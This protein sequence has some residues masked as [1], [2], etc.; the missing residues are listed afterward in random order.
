MATRR[1]A[2]NPAKLRA[3]REAMESQAPE[4]APG[5]R[6]LLHG[7]LSVLLLHALSAALL[8][9]SFA[10]FNYWY[11]AYVALVP[12]SLA[13]LDEGRPRWGLL[14]S[15]LGGVLFWASNLYWLWWITL[16]GYF[17]LV[18]YLSVYWLVGAWVVR[19]A[20]RRRIPAWIA[21]PLIWTSLEYARAHV[22]SGFPWLFLAHSQYLQ[23]RLIQIVD[24]TGQYGVS[25]FVALV[26]GVLVELLSGPLVGR[27]RC[28][29]SL[30]RGLVGASVAA[31]AVAGLM[32]YGHW[33]VN[34]EVTR[35]GPVIGVVQQD[36]R[37]ALGG[38]DATPEKT[39][40]SHLD[41]TRE[42]LIGA[43]CDLVVWPETMLPESLNPEMLELDLMGLSRD[44]LLCL[45]AIVGLS[46]EDA[47]TWPD[48]GLR[49]LLGTYLHSG[50]ALPLEDRRVLQVVSSRQHAERVTAL[51]GKLDCPI[52]AGGTTVH[53]SDDPVDTWD[54]FV[55]RN[56]LLWFDG[57]GLPEWK[58]AKRHLVPLSEFV[59]F[60][61]TWPW[62]YAQLRRLIPPGM[63]QL[64]PGDSLEPLELTNEQGDSWRLAAAICYEGTFPRVCR[65][66][67]APEGRKEVD[68]LLNLSND[69][70]FVWRWG[71]GPSR[72]STEHS[73]HLVHYCFRAI[74]NRV[75]VVRAVNTGI[76]ASVDSLGRVVAS[77]QLEGGPWTVIPG[78]LL[79]DGYR[80]GERSYLYVNGPQ[81]LVD[82]RVSLYSLVGDAF[83]MLVS[84][85]SSLLALV[86]VLKR[87]KANQEVQES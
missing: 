71:D 67:V 6:L 29:G 35:A 12:W 57:D 77:L 41:M 84:G 31:V 10:P 14:C 82:A 15:Y 47:K 66:L 60:K 7:R 9:A 81:I 24:V 86:L 30:R 37:I 74:E 32:G 43:G 75:P 34:Q 3:D 52:L 25:F 69:G 22:A 72:L 83:A 4:A 55:R 17:A 11:L 50:G 59:P 64:E 44:D 73:Q 18:A 23:T 62:L 13:L 76:S 20:L 58:Y 63:P 8:S 36:F 33:R 65:S 48:K 40:Q 16:P 1:R 42:R 2:M 70:W 45:G 80:H 61:K 79:L 51:A 46:H 53:R 54:R 68:I 21:L 56:S 87:R 78:T 85:V 49:S 27:A 26:S 19:A 39:L 28:A 38:S 5:R